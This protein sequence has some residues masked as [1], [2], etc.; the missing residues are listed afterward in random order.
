MLHE[1]EGDSGEIAAAAEAA[2][3][4]VGVFACHLHLLFSLEAYYGLVQAHM[5][6]NRAQHVFATRGLGCEFH[7]LGD[8][9][10]ERALVVGLFG[11]N[12][13]AGPGTH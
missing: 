11:Y 5:V 3:H 4:D 9:R 1:R 7:G 2:D 8:G 6:E 13:F 12:V 10:T